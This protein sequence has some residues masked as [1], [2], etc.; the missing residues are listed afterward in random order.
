ME[1]TDELLYSSDA[2]ATEYLFFCDLK[3]ENE[4]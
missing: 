2:R 3:I 4:K 1:S